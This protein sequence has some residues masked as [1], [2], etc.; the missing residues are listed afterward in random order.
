MVRLVSC[1]LLFKMPAQFMREKVLLVLFALTF[2]LMAYVSTLPP[3][4]FRNEITEWGDLNSLAYQEFSEYR[5]KFGANEAVVL[6]WPGCDLNDP[7]VEEVAVGIETQLADYVHNVFSGQ[8]AYVVLR[9]EVKLTDAAALKR[10]R[11][12]FV[13]QDDRVTAVGFQLSGAARMNR[14]DCFAMLD[15]IL[16]AANVDP[17]EVIYAGLG[18]NLYTLDKEGLESP[19]RMVPQII[20]LAFGLTVVFLRD[21]R[22]AFFI[23][24]L[25]IYTGCL[26]FN[27]VWLADV[28]MNAI[29]WPLPTLTM[30]L[31]VSTSLHFLS[32]FRKS[33]VSS[34]R[35]GDLALESPAN[36]KASLIW[37][38]KI[39]ADAVRGSLKPILYCTATTA[40]GLL[41]LML[42]T[43]QPVRQFG[44]F[45]ALSILVGNSLLLVWLPAWLTWIGYAERLKSDR[46][47]M[48]SAEQ[49]NDSSSRDRF[50]GWQR[51]ARLTRIGRWPITAFCFV[52]FVVGAFGI[53]DVKTGSE[54]VNFFPAGH[55]VLTSAKEMESRVGSMNSVELLLKFDDVDPT[56]DRLKI[57][58]L[59]TLVSR[60]ESETDFESCLSAA[61]FAPKLLGNQSGLRGGVERA[62]LRRFKDR[63]ASTGLLYRDEN[64]K[65]ETWRV[66]CRYSVFNELDL[67]EQT[68]KLKQ[69]V[70][71]LFEPDNKIVFKGESLTTTVTGE[72][73]LFDFIDS[74][75]FKE[76]LLTYFTAFVVISLMVLLVLRSL[77]ASLIALL[78]NLFPALVVLGTAGFLG[79]SLD[80][81]S[82]TTASVA[83]GIAVDD[84][85]H[86]LLW[87]REALKRGGTQGSKFNSEEVVCSVLQ[88]CGIAVV[89]TS[90][91][92]GLSMVLYA[93]CGFLPTVR[94]G[95]LLSAMMFAALVGDLLLLPALLA[96]VARLPKVARLQN[97]V[98]S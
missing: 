71:R 64:K 79:F 56:N 54:L 13:G 34:V 41:S 98:H 73:V 15:N 20:L 87:Y 6:S 26:S 18:H 60:I 80:V 92:L 84:T 9:S 69:I 46:S 28:D 42:S 31:T 85:L 5:D 50:D 48:D 93:F 16:V 57:K 40:I 1:V 63:I 23:N 97:P 36:S 30:L 11:N 70:D 24:A 44:L 22:L 75:F 62:R 96:I 78:P 7:R 21:L 59:Q 66:S 49:A 88:Y 27:I 72:F 68:R 3:Q 81:A 55:R 25:G 45:G 38:R 65:H 67:V 83:L 29:I 86:F 61:V 12:V 17:A 95:V 35:S 91:I 51:W 90:V 43:C 4:R 74:Q 2:P 8:R 58:G 10:L 53:P 39:V 82:L 32:Y 19:F 14:A 52:V 89:Q 33:V 37:R 77:T 76:L 47:L 94:F